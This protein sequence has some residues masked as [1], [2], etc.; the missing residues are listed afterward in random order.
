[1]LHSVLCQS[2]YFCTFRKPSGPLLVFLI[3]NNALSAV[4]ID[5]FEFLSFQFTSQSGFVPNSLFPL[6]TF[7]TISMSVL[8]LDG[9]DVKPLVD[10]DLN[11]TRLMNMCLKVK[12]K[13]LVTTTYKQVE[14]TSHNLT[15]LSQLA[16]YEEK[17]I[18][19]VS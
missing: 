12:D 17:K 7:T 9:A 11:E 4:T 1:M 15:Q 8:I 3:V 2:L 19:Q 16:N 18:T 5:F 6:T 10:L 14:L 13:G